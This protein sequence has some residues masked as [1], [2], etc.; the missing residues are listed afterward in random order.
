LGSL[1]NSVIFGVLVLS[2]LQGAEG[3]GRWKVVA[4]AIA[5]IFVNAAIH[6]LIPGLVGALASVLATVVF[7]GV[8][9]VTWCE[10]ER[11]TAFRILAA[12]FGC[13]LV[14]NIFSALVSNPPA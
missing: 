6:E 1:L 4:V 14:L 3:A 10:I 11:R 9:L 8:A 7:V 13:S 5:S 12:Y 2:L